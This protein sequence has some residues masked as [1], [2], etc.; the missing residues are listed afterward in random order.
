MVSDGWTSPLPF[1]PNPS[2]SSEWKEKVGREAVEGGVNEQPTSGPG[3]TNLTERVS[4]GSSD[5]T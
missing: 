5:A 3:L 2:P 4:F 1:H